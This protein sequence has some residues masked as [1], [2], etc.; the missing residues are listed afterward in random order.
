MTQKILI[1]DDNPD[2]TRFLARLIGNELHL[3]TRIAGSAEEALKIL[4]KEMVNCLLVDMKM[5]GM[6]GMEL[7]RRDQEE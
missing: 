4:D 5:P 3:E 2:M 7:L 6:D 1:V